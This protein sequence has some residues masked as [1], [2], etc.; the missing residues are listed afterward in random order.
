MEELT[1]QPQIFGIWGDENGDDGDKS[2]VGEA[3][4]S[5]ATLCFGDSMTGNSGHSDT[6]VLYI[7]FKGTDAV[8]GA[9]GANWEA[10]S[11][12]EF[13]SSLETLGTKL[14]RRIGASNSTAASPSKSYSTARPFSSSASA[15]GASPASEGASCSWAHHCAGKSTLPRSGR[16]LARGLSN[17]DTKG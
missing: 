14:L 2:M 4:I 16:G 9:D 3:A 15:S 17:V 10:T 7:A 8:P 6:D 12:D 11:A 1:N 5:T 13:E